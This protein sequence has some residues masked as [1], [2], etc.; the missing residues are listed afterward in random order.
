MIF[1]KK[2]N[3]FLMFKDK[4]IFYM[5][6][7]E[8]KKQIVEHDQ[9]IL[10]Q[11]VLIDGQLTNDTLVKKR[12]EFFVQEKKLKKAKVLFI[13]PDHFSMI[14]KEEI[15]VQLEEN[16]IEN[17]LSLHLNSSI[18]LPFDSPKIDF[19]ILEKTAESQYLL[20]T[21]YPKEQVETYQGLIEGVQL[22]A[23]VADFSYISVYRAFINSDK[24]FHSKED[25]LLLIQWHPFDSSLSVFH[26]DIPQFHRHTNFTR[27]AQNWKQNS[28]G[29]WEWTS[30][31]QELEL[32]IDEQLNAIERFLDFYKFSIMNGEKMVT[33]V[34]LTG[35]YPKLDY[36]FERLN[37]RIDLKI[38]MLELPL[39]L[40][41][42][43][44]PLY[45]LIS[46]KI[47][48]GR[49]NKKRNKKIKANN[50]EEDKRIND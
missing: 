30:T 27:V 22:Q 4:S 19:Q 21:A 39:D 28:K 23:Y 24:T 31:E 48:K 49:L 42:I 33:K 47:H 15:P 40:D 2:P 45:G 34:L 11:P 32:V 17:Y 25:H 41:Q 12:L 20:L 43:F 1:N 46:K 3:L 8:Q 37:E 16:E 13:L 6:Y 38:K 50:P 14:R 44:A 18:R 29:L 10:D 35:H 9:I 7:D 36:L 5:I 26:D